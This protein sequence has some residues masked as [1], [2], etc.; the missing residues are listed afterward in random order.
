MK[1][2]IEKILNTTL[3]QFRGNCPLDITD[4]VFLEI[5]KSFLSNYE[6]GAKVNG[7]DKLNIFIGKHI[8]EYWHLKNEGR[9]NSPRS[10]LITSYE[11]HSNY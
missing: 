11:K 3:K 9:C 2:I 6:R 5:E 10:R 1:E 4:L 8:K 7:I